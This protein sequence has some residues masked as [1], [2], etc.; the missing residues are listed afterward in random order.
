MKRLNLT[1]EIANCK[2]SNVFS[3]SFFHRIVHKYDVSV[4]TAPSSLIC[5]NL[6]AMKILPNTVALLTV[7]GR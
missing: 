4:F 5:K 3:N 2:M 7:T 1:N 6:T